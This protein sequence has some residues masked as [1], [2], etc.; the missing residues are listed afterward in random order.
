[1]SKFAFLPLILLHLCQINIAMSKQIVTELLSVLIVCSSWNWCHLNLLDAVV[2][3]IAFLYFCSSNSSDISLFWNRK[4]YLRSRITLQ[5]W[6][7]AKENFCSKY[8]LYI[9][10]PNAKAKF[11]QWSVQN[12]QINERISSAWLMWWESWKF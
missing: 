3:E 12:Y 10:V 5:D 8:R 11:L 9:D 4:L 7:H 6:K 2:R 1:M